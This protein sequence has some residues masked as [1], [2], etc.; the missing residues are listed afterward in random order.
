MKRIT[1][2]PQIWLGLTFN[3]GILLG[4]SAFE[5]HLAGAPLLLYGASVFWT[6]GYD[7]IYAHQDKED[8][9]MVGVKSSAIRL[10]RNSK[11]WIGA[12]YGVAIGLTLAAGL[13]AGLGL[14]FPVG[15]VV[16]GAHLMRQINRVDIDN[17]DMCLSVFKSNR[18][19]GFIILAAILIGHVT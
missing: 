8:D 17:P 9:L 11:F 3:W 2:W 14:L 7:T 1:Y 4:W 10:G 18:D 16:G 13:V 19:F 5:G 15:L 6:L 12:F